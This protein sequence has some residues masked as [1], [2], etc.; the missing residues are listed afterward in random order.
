MRKQI[1]PVVVL[2]FF[3]VPFLS[4]QEKVNQF[5]TNGNRDGV[6]I[7]YHT[8]KLIRYKGQFKNGKEIGVFKFYSPNTNEFPESVKTF[9]EKNDA[10]KVE[11]YNDKG[12]VVSIGNM[13]K[14]NRVGKWL[15]FNEDGKTIMT[16]ENYENGA[17]NGISKTFFPNGKLA[18]VKNYKNG[19]L[20]GG[21]KRYAD[22]GNLLDDLSY[23]NGKLHG[24]A[25]YYNIDGAL[26]YTGFYENDEK[27]GEW[28]YYENGKK[29]STDKLKQ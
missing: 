26:I 25:K 10:A 11:F 22:N 16:E 1:V 12:V 9:S 20:E 28:E 21:L 17:L 8:N 4:A 15:Y 14:K 27:I 6:W 7:K 5:D 29:V 24:L 23:S 19:K 13:I 2:L 3:I 18:E